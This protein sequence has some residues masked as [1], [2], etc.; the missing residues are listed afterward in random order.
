LKQFILTN[1]LSL[2]LSAMRLAV[3]SLTVSGVAAEL[4]L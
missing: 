2:S 4:D 1:L 3:R